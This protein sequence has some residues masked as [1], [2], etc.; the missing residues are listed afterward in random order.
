MWE[1]GNEF[2]LLNC[3]CSFLNDPKPEGLLKRC[4]SLTPGQ[5]QTVSSVLVL[6]LQAI[7]NCFHQKASAHH[8]ST[9][10]P[11]AESKPGVTAFILS[12]FLYLGSDFCLALHLRYKITKV[13]KMLQSYKG[14]SAYLHCLRCLPS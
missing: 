3:S 8:L 7:K 4:R 1:E 13:T 14:V 2:I 12:S 11:K 5:G 9:K 10:Q 6:I